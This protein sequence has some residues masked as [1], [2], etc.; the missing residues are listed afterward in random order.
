MLLD[1]AGIA[2]LDGQWA[3][4]L[5]MSGAGDAHG[6]RHGLHA[7]GVD[8]RIHALEMAPA[9]EALGVAAAAG[10]VA[11][12][13]ALASADALAEVSAWLDG[14]PRAPGSNGAHPATP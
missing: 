5:R 10:A 6:D 1:G 2:A 3:M 14:E 4:A 12:G 7:Q 11:A 8:R 13:R 9:R